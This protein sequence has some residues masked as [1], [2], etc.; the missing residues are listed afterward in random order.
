MTV[1]IVV[2]LM[3]IVFVMLLITYTI[4]RLITLIIFNIIAGISQLFLGIYRK[5]G[6]LAGRSVPSS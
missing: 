4:L 3:G 1:G 2:L 6:N 5:I